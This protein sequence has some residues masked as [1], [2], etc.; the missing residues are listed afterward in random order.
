MTLHLIFVLLVILGFVFM[1][2]STWPT[3]PFPSTRI[4]WGCWLIAAL[5]W[6]LAGSSTA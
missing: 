3:P 4:A 6:A 2:A 1:F 5:L